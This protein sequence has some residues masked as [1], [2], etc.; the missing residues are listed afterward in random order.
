MTGTGTQTDPF[1]VDN[2]EDFLT[3]SSN[4][5]YVEWSENSGIIDF[6]DIN[7]EGYTSEIRLKCSEFNGWTFKNLHFRN[8]GKFRFDNGAN[9]LNLLD[10]YADDMTGSCFQF[11]QNSK[12]LK[13][14]GIFHARSGYTNSIIL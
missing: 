13:I 12:N 11:Y 7:P 9:D 14:S 3:A 10:F 4:S 1:V 2:W 6:N 5:N 8:G